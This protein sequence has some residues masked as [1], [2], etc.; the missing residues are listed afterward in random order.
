MLLQKPFDAITTSTDGDCLMVLARADEEFTASQVQ[1]LLEG[2]R[3]LSG[4]RN[5]L[6]RLDEQGVVSGRRVANAITY[7]LNR[8]HILSEAIETIARAKQILIDKTRD[9][10]ADWEIQP[11]FAAIFGSAARGEMRTD[12][13]IDVL[14]IRPENADW[15]RWTDTVHEFQHAMTSW[16]GNDVRI[17]ELSEHEA[18][19]HGA[20]DPVMLEIARDGIA[21][22]GRP[23][24]KRSGAS[25]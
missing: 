1:R 6:D 13:D 22:T 12:S 8:E 9:A 14:L 10:V 7:R 23:N 16:T 15:E 21:I 2:R 11:V 4:V 5:S 18:R 17:L 3:S 24:W 20:V 25:S 19:T